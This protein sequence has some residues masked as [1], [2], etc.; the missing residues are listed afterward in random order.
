[1]IKDDTTV[2][3]PSKTVAYRNIGDS[4]VIVDIKN[5]SM[6]RLND[7]G[8]SIWSLLGEL[9]VAQIAA[10]IHNQFDV[11]KTQSLIDTHDF[12]EFMSKRELVSISHDND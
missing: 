4:A 8:S 3:I 5:N 2:Y 6:I 7:T 1:M 9:S 12:L 11:T 10:E